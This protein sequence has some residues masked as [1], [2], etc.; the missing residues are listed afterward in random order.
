MADSVSPSTLALPV[1]D[2]LLARLHGAAC[3]TCG[4]VEASLTAA[5]RIYTGDQDGGRLGWP[6]VEWISATRNPAEH[7]HAGDLAGGN[8]AAES[9]VRGGLTARLRQSHADVGRDTGCWNSWMAV[10][11]RSREAASGW[12]PAAAGC[13][14]GWSRSTAGGLML[15]EI[16]TIGSLIGLIIT[17]LLLGW[18]TRAV[19]QQTQIANNIAGAG[20]L[21]DALDDVR[22]VLLILVERPEL[23]KYLY[24]NKP[25]PTVGLERDR[26]LALVE[27][28]ADALEAGLLSTRRVSASESFDDWSAYTSY[29]LAHS[30]TLASMVG[31]HEGWWPNM[32]KLLASGGTGQPLPSP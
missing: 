14:P 6:V 12:R 9:G 21:H 27:I 10:L 1:D 8:A 20:V 30:P 11:S 4:T 19:A 15:A 13:Q 7:D 28:L 23:R 5:G 24:D 18:Q 22:S 16:G 25:C 26:I 17:L 3:F 32:A 31:Q 29:M 2:A